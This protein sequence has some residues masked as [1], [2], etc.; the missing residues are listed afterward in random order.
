MNRK[1]MYELNRASSRQHRAL[2]KAAEAYLTIGNRDNLSK[3]YDLMRIRGKTRGNTT[4][5]S[6]YEL[7]NK[8]KH[9]FISGRDARDIMYDYII[10]IQSIRR[11]ARTYNKS[12]K[13]QLLRNSTMSVDYGDRNFALLRDVRWLSHQISGWRP[14]IIGMLTPIVEMHTSNNR[15]D[16][17]NTKLHQ[18]PRIA[19]LR[20]DRVNEPIES[21]SY[22]PLVAT[23][24]FIIKF[25]DANGNQ[26][27][28]DKIAD[29]DAWDVEFISDDNK[30]T[31][32]RG[33]LAKF[34]TEFGCSV[35]LSD[36][37]KAAKMRAVRKAKKALGL[38]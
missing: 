16:F 11:D 38:A 34:G 8:L 18:T 19:K 20:K 13:T 37:T 36:A 26:C 14:S 7:E 28:P 1:Q 3:L 33:V 17:A 10:R 6:M 29:G 5:F 12:S 31:L 21:D 25:F 35:T 23:D 32:K 27:V 22:V 30:P 4:T 2:F 24:R 15:V 9:D